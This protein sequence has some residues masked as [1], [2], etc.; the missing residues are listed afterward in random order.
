MIAYL[1]RN[2]ERPRGLRRAVRVWA[3]RV[4]NA[5]GLL[6][7]LGRR[8]RLQRRGAQVG[9]LSI[10]GES[11]IEGAIEKLRIGRESFIGRCEVSLHDAVEIG[12]RV[13]INDGVQLLTGTHSLSDPAW[14]LQTRPI[15]IGD[16][17]WIAQGAV[18]LPGVLIGRGAVVGAAAV[19]RSDV[20]DFAVALGNPALVTAGRRGRHLDYSP[21]RMVASVEA[22][23]GPDPSARHR[24]ECVSNAGK[25]A[26]E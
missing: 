19:V 25:G 2:R 3:K 1:W 14:G 9:E 7:Q 18:V 22:W 8:W 4:L 24:R 12:D 17:A 21:I 6:H 11:R 15:R 23:L 16:Y 10:I 26:A 5:P 13:V 20:P